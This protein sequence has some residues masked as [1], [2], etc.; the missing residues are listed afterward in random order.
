MLT[1]FGI[2]RSVVSGV[3][4]RWRLFIL[5][6]SVCVSKVQHN[7]LSPPFGWASGP[8]DSSSRRRASTPLYHGFKEVEENWSKHFSSGQKEGCQQEGD[9]CWSLL[10][11]LNLKSIAQWLLEELWSGPQSPPWGWS[12]TCWFRKVV[13][14]DFYMLHSVNKLIIFQMQ[15]HNPG[16]TVSCPQRPLRRICTDSILWY[17]DFVFSFSLSFFLYFFLTLLLEFSFS[18]FFISYYFS[19]IFFLFFFC[20]FSLFLLFFLL[21]N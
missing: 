4:S 13:E 3:N 20:L 16:S 17:W 8:Q 6:S 14:I 7:L 12:I 10:V 5:N 9:D 11:E 2:I 18:F 21:K 15:P 19:G 1:S